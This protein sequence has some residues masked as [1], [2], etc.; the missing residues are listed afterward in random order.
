MASNSA[1]GIQVDPE[2]AK[3][4]GINVHDLQRVQDATAGWEHKLIPVTFV[5]PTAD[6]K[7]MGRN[8]PM[9]WLPPTYRGYGVID[10]D[11][12]NRIRPGEAWFVERYEQGSA[13]FLIPVAKITATSIMDL[14]PGQMSALVREMM[15]TNPALANDVIKQAP[16]PGAAERKKMED[17]EKACSILRGDLA[18]AQDDLHQ[19]KARVQELEDK[20]QDL[21]S[22]PAHP[23]LP[24]VPAAPAV[25]S[26]QTTQ[27][28]AQ[29]QPMAFTVPNMAFN[30]TGIIHHVNNGTLQ[31]AMLTA[32]FY[33][34]HY[35]ADLESLFL[36]PGATGHPCVNGAIHVPGLSTV[37]PAKPPQDYEVEWDSRLGAL[38]VYLA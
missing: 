8:D 38:H 25:K 32:P 35:S 22:R 14:M 6:R 12:K 11:H 18:K 36:K 23:A 21:Q 13:T 2:L 28:T 19:K 34:A 9:A 24:S 29:S 20:V 31:G 1:P 10:R 27:S 16:Q 33:E 30:T 26:V 17:L 4:L 15:Q 5:E 3:R 37:V 7:S